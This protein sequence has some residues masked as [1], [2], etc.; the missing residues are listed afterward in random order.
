HRQAVDRPARGP[1][2]TTQPKDQQVEGGEG[3]PPGPRRTSS[4]THAAPANEATFPAPAHPTTARSTARPLDTQSPMGNQNGG[5]SSSGCTV[6][7]VSGFGGVVSPVL[8]W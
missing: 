8:C 7:R 3:P 5:G 6:G 1:R 4:Q 2:P